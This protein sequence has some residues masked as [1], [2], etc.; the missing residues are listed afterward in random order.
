MQTDKE[1]VL[2]ALGGVREQEIFM[3][4][5]DGYK[6]NEIA[7]TLQISPRTVDTYLARIKGNL[8]LTSM[9][10]LRRLAHDMA[11]S[12]VHHR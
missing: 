9:Q 7:E 4:L 2:K 8:E 1:S 6:R 3:L 12:F 11:E 5:G 10:E